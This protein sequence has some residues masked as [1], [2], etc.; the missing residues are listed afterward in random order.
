MIVPFG[1][2][3][4]A[5]ELFLVYS[6]THETY[7]LYGGSEQNSSLIQDFGSDNKEHQQDNLYPTVADIDQI[8]QGY[9]QN[10]H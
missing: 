9:S 1:S 8:V 4:V 5:N 3:V 7:Q 6:T 10:M 2:K